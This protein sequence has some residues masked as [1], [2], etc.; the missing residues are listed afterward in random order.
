MYQQHN[1]KFQDFFCQIRT[2]IM[3]V[4]DLITL[5]NH[6]IQ[7]LLSIDDFDITYVMRFN[8]QC[9]YI[10]QLQFWHFAKIW[11]QD[12]Y[13]FSVIHYHIKIKHDSL[14]ID[15]L[16][17]TSDE[18]HVKK[19]DLFFYIKKMLITIFYN[20]CIFLRLINSIWN[21]AADIVSDFNNKLLTQ[22][23]HQ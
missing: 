19:S 20:I 14:S 4:I 3:T 8:K 12:I 13:M 22:L 10:N 23:K 18:N 7:F 6:V 16:L 11:N 2:E 1:L 5:N 17:K 9:H 21:T 15:K